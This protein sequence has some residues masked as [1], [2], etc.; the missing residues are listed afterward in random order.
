MVMFY[1]IQYDMLDRQFSQHLQPEK[2]PEKKHVVMKILEHKYSVDFIRTD[3]I[4]LS[5]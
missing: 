1:M 4:M 5:I 3:L 2:Q